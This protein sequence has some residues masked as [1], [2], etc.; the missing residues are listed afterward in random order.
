[1]GDSRSTKRPAELRLGRTVVTRESGTLAVPSAQAQ[2]SWKRRGLLSEKAE[3]ALQALSSND[4][5]VVV[6]E[7]VE[8]FD[9][10]IPRHVGRR[11][12]I[13]DPWRAYTDAVKAIEAGD[14]IAEDKTVAARLGVSE[15]TIQE[16]RRRGYIPGGRKGRAKA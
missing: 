11:P 13:E 6:L 7:T 9:P 15:R 2:K 5:K 1:M 16:W 8:P 3:A 12:M 10:P 14:W 4:G